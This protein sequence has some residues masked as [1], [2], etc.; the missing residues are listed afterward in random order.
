MQNLGQ[1]LLFCCIFIKYVKQLYQNF[2]RCGHFTRTYCD[3]SMGLNAPHIPRYFLL[4]LLYILLFPCLSLL[5]PTSHFSIFIFINM[6]AAHN[7]YI[8]YEELVHIIIHLNYLSIP[9][10]GILWSSDPSDTLPFC[11]KIYLFHSY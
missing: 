9:S 8:H 6:F 2:T 10:F 4:I 1:Q 5:S 3:G 7:N 11:K